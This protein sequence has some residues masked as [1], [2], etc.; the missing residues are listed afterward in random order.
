MCQVFTN[1]HLA[2]ARGTVGECI[3]DGEAAITS[4]ALCF[5]RTNLARARGTSP[6]VLGE[7]NV[8]PFT[9]TVGV[10]RGTVGECTCGAVALHQRCGAGGYATKICK[11]NDAS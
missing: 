7:C 10:A 5:A 11:Q 4:V 6:T 9:V 3:G 1:Q 2:R 8:T